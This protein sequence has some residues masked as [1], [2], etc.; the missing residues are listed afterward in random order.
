MKNTAICGQYGTPLPDAQPAGEGPACL[1]KRRLGEFEFA[2]GEELP[3]SFVPTGGLLDWMSSVPPGT[4]PLHRYRMILSR[5]AT[6]VPVAGG[7]E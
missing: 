5:F 1:L 3:E 6:T 4:A 7:A 2:G